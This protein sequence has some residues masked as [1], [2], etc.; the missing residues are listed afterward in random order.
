MRLFL[1]AAA[2][3]ASAVAQDNYLYISNGIIRVGVDLS[4]GGSI[5][6]LAVRL[7]WLLWDAAAPAISDLVCCAL[8]LL[9]A[10]CAQQHQ[11]DQLPRYAMKYSFH[12]RV[13][14]A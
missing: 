6:F 3:L 9:E 12:V 8:A 1:L 14:S 11:R 4:R 10:G 2:W 13:V 7:A 5:G